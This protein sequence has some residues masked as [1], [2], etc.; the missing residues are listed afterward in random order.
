[1]AWAGASVTTGAFLACLLVSVIMTPTAN[2]LRLPF[3]GLAFAC[4]VSLI[5]G[6]YIFRMVAG[7]IDLATLGSEPSGGLLDQVAADG[8]SACFILLAMALGL[9][10]PKM[11]IEHFATAKARA[12]R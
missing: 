4:V 11:G 2:Y 7:A 9:V 1:M 3:A 10:L 6:V 12:V 8:I 5:P